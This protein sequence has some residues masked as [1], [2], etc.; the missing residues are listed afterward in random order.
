M[1]K[2]H[3]CPRSCSVAGLQPVTQRTQPAGNASDLAQ[4]GRPCGAVS[5]RRLRGRRRSSPKAAA[6]SRGASAK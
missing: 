2:V 5:C 6:A 1:G 3:E 4:Q